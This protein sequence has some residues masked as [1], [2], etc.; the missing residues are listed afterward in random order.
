MLMP[1]ADQQR[2]KIIIDEDWKSQ[3]QAEKERLQ[4]EL[5]RKQQSGG[6][7]EAPVPPATFPL[8]ITTL[9][10]QALMFLGQMPNPLTGKVELHLEQAKHF[11]DTLQMLQEKTKGNL[12]VDESQ[13]L[14]QILHE[15]RLAY[16][17]LGSRPQGKD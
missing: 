4:A 10:T 15:L 17:T 5:E 12:T 2:S 8:H 13:M 7:S 3:A 14:E 6:E 9:A 11:I 1:D 16:V